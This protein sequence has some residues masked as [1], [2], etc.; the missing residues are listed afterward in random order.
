MARE[1]NIKQ[2]VDWVTILLY[3]TLL[4]IGWLNIYAAVYKPDEAMTLFS[5]DHRA[6]LQMLFI[7]G[8]IFIIML[9]LF[10]DHNIYDTLAY[11]FY[12]V[13]IV[14]LIAT[15]F[16]ATDIK[17]SRSWLKIGTFSVQPAEFAKIVTA[18]AL[19]KY[20]SGQLVNITKFSDAIKAILIIVVPPIIIILQNETGSA[21]TFA[22]LIIPLYR[23]GLP[24]VFPALGITFIILFVLALVFPKWWIVAGIAILCLLFFRFVLKKREQNRNNIFRIVAIFM[25]ASGFIFGVDFLLND[26]LKPHQQKRITVLVNPNVDP[27]GVGW[28]VNQSRIAI[29]SGGFIGKGYLQGTQTKFDYVP[30]QETD[31]IFCTVGE[32]W[33]FVG[34]VTVIVLFLVL[35]TR[36][37]NLA[38]KQGRNT[39]A[40]IYGYCVAGYL[41]FHLM[42]NI[43]MTIGLMPVI[44]IPLPLISY[45]GSSLWSFTILLFIFIKLDAHRSFKV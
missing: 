31:F 22:A 12:G 27:M 35:I 4:I 37:I 42:I 40:R 45:G 29:S 21:L 39:F 17:G 32:E 2:G 14:I 11:I 23:E 44:G 20:L 36:L 8:A 5:L 30:E 3:A 1:I 7:G 28:N 43:G 13:A 19:S 18:L 34:S 16:L 9:I 6:G 38:E 10:I 25:L 41:F 24:G 26:V 15:I 33:G